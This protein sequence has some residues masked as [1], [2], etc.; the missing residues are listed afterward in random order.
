MNFHSIW[1]FLV[2][3]CTH[4]PNITAARLTFGA[5]YSHLP[6][7]LPSAYFCMSSSSLFVSAAI[8]MRLRYILGMG[9]AALV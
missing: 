8:F 9:V 6:A 1:N 7:L 4:E 5:L 2:P 3:V